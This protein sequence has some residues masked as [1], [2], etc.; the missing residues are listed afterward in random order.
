MIGEALTE[1]KAFTLVKGWNVIPEEKRP[2]AK[3]KL[4]A[5]RDERVANGEPLWPN[6][7]AAR[8]RAEAERMEKLWLSNDGTDTADSMMVRQIDFMSAVTKREPFQVASEPHRYR[9]AVADYLGDPAAADSPEAFD[10]LTRQYI[11][12]QRDRRLLIDG[13]GNPE[14]PDNGSSLVQF[15]ADAARAGR[16]AAESFADWSRGASAKPGYEAAMRE[17]E[18]LF[19]HFSRVHDKARRQWQDFEGRAEGILKELEARTDDGSPMLETAAALPY[20]DG[21]TPPQRDAVLGLVVERAKAKDKGTGQQTGEAVG[22]V[23][24]R[25]AEAQTDSVVRT[26]LGSTAFK[27]GQT[28]PASLAG[29]PGGL[30]RRQVSRTQANVGAG[31]FGDVSGMAGAVDGAFDETAKLTKQQ[32]DAANKELARQRESVA[33]EAKLR[34]IAQGA[35]DPVKGSNWFTDKV[36]YPALNI[37]GSIGSF[38]AP[39]G[40]AANLAAYVEDEQSRLEEAGVS[41]EAV[42]MQAPLVGGV[43]AVLDRIQLGMLRKLPAFSGFAARLTAPAATGAGAFAQRIPGALGVAVG[44]SAIEGMQDA[45]PL[46]IQKVF[47]ALGAD[48]PD[49]E[50]SEIAKESWAAV[51][52]TFFGMLPLVMLGAGVGAARDYKNVRSLVG[53]ASALRQIGFADTQI[54]RI[55]KAGDAEAMVRALRGEWG[56]RTPVIGPAA[57]PQEQANLDVLRDPSAPAGDVAAAAQTQ[58]GVETVRQVMAEMQAAAG[59][60]SIRHTASGWVLV[61]EDGNSVTTA[62]PEEARAAMVSIGRARSEREAR[63]MTDLIEYFGGQDAA[64]GVGSVTSVAKAAVFARTKEDGTTEAVAVNPGETDSEVLNWTDATLGNLAAEM[65]AA[66]LTEAAIL[67]MNSALADDAGRMVRAYQTNAGADI[68]TILHERFERLYREGRVTQEQVWWAAN[69]LTSLPQFDPARIRDDGQRRVAE[70]LRRIATEDPDVTD[71]ER[72]ETMIDLVVADVLGMWQDGTKLPAGAIEAGIMEASMVGMTPED[73]AAMTTF[74]AVWR[75]VKG[76][77]KAMF[78]I[79]SRI[80]SARRKGQI[81]EGDEWSAFVDTLLRVDV[82]KRHVEQVVDEAGSMSIAAAGGEVYQSRDEEKAQT[83]KASSGSVFA[84]NGGLQDRDAEWSRRG[85][86]FSLSPRAVQGYFDFNAVPAEKIEANPEDKKSLQAIVAAE[87]LDAEKRKKE[88]EKAERAWA[89]LVG[90]NAALLPEALAALDQGPVSSL[91]HGLISREIPAWDV[92]GAVIQGPEDILALTQAV[93]SPFV[94]SLK[95]IVVGD[96][97]TVVGSRIVTVG[98]LDETSAHPRE[99]FASIESI[100][101]GY[102]GKIRGWIISHNHP[103]G[104]PEPSQA[105]RRFTRVIEDVSNAYGIPLLD[106]VVTN[107]SRY[108]SFRDAGLMSSGSVGNADARVGSLPDREKPE[109]QKL[110]QTGKAEWEVIEREKRRDF[111]PDVMRE[112]ALNATSTD[113]NHHHV[114][115]LSVRMQIEAIERIKTDNPDEVVKAVIRG[116]GREG[117]KSIALIVAGE[118]QGNAVASKDKGFV[119]KVTDGLRVAMIGVTDAAQRGLSSTWRESG[120]MEQGPA[121]FSIGASQDAIHASLE[122]RAKAGDAAAAQEAQRM[123]D[124]AAE[125]AG[126]SGISDFRMEHSA[127]DR[128]TH[129]LLTVRKSG[130]V[131]ADYWTR[132]DWYVSSPEEM[133]S[134]QAIRS[135]LDRAEAGNPKVR[136]WVFRAVPKSVKETAPRN[137]D[138]VTPSEA[139]AKLEGASI[140]GG[141]KIIKHNALLSELW[142]DGNSA[143]ELGFDDGNGYVYR[144]TK[145]NRKLLDPFTYDEGNLVPLSKRFNARRWETSFSISGLAQISRPTKKDD[146]FRVGTSRRIVAKKALPTPNTSNIDFENV[147]LEVLAKQMAQLNY[148]HLPADIL[149]EQDAR[150]KALKFIEWLRDNLLA[151]HDAFPQDV[152]A[153]ATLWYDGANRIAKRL[154]KQWK[155]TP[156]QAAGVM[157]VLSPQ[158]DWFKNVAQAEQVFDI[159]STERDTVI[160]KEI[161]QTAGE[162]I[163]QAALADSN[164]KRK[165]KTKAGEKES[166]LARTRRIKFNRRLQ[167]AAVEERRVIFR[168]MEGR[169]IAEMDDDPEL[170]AWAIRMLAQHKFGRFYP[171]LSPE[172]DRLDL[173]LT[174]AGRPAFN[175]W[176]SCLEIIKCVSILKDGSLENISAQLGDEHKV[177]SFYNNIIAPNSPFGDTTMDTHAVAAANLMPFA[178][179]DIEVRHNLGS[180]SSS[181]PLGISGMYHLYLK[182]YRDAAA[183]RGLQPRQMQSITWEAIR[184]L[185]PSVEKSSQNLVEQIAEIWQSGEDVSTIR[186]RIL[187]RGIPSPI[188]AGTGNGG[189]SGGASAVV[190]KTGA[191]LESGTDLRDGDRA[192]PGSSGRG[193]RGRG[194]LSFSLGSVNTLEAIAARLEE[195]ASEGGAEAKLEIYQNLSRTLDGMARAARANEETEQIIAAGQ[196]ETKR[197]ALQQKLEDDYILEIYANPIGEALTSD[198]ATA[199]KENEFLRQFIDPSKKGLVGRFR[200]PKRARA[201]GRG[202]GEYED[203]LRRGLPS[204]LFRGPDSPAGAPDVIAS[205]LDMPMDVPEMW[206]RIELELDSVARARASLEK[207]QDAVREAKARARAEAKDWALSERAKLAASD[208][209]DES[210][211]LVTLDAILMQLPAEVRGRLGGFTKLS[212]MKRN[213]VRRAHFL[214]MIGQIDIELERYLR[215]SYLTTIRELFAKSRP[216]RMAGEKDRGRLGVNAHTWVETAE[217]ASKLGERAL[218]ERESWIESRLSGSTPLDDAEIAD[219]NRAWDLGTGEDAARMALEQESAILDLFGGMTHS[220]DGTPVKGSGELEAALQALRATITT[221]RMAREAEILKRRADRETRRLQLQADAKNGGTPGEIKAREESMQGLGGDAVKF[222]RKGFSFEQLVGDIF[223]RGS[224]TH[225]FAEDTVIEA[226]LAETAAFNRAQSALADLMKSLWP[227]TGK[228]GRL[229]NMEAMATPREVPGAPEGS[230]RFSQMEA[231][232]MTMLWADMDSRDWLTMHGFGEET[233]AALEA[234]LTPEAMAIRSWL[235]EWYDAQYDDLNEVYRRIHGTNMPRVRNYSPRMVEHGKDAVAID[236][237][238]MGGLSARGVFSGFTKRRRPALAAAPVLADAL[239]AWAQ[240]QRVVTHFLSWA[241][242]SS[243]L[244]AVF[245]TSATATYVK[246]AAGQQ[247]ATDLNQWL[248]DLEAGG[249]ADAQGSALWKRWLRAN[250][251]DKLFGKLGVLAKQIPAMY[252]SAAEVGWPEWIRSARRVLAG[253]AAR[254]RSEA[255]ESRIMQGRAFTR[256]DEFIQA[257]RARGASP[258][259]GYLRRASGGW[260]DLNAIDVALREIGGAIGRTDAYFTGFSAAVAYDAKFLEAKESGDSDEAAH[261][262]AERETERVISRTAQPETLAN[263]SLGENHLGTWGRILFMFQS[264]NRQALYMTFAAFRDGGMKSPEAWRKAVTHWVLTGLVTQTVGSIV[265]DIM[266]DDDEDEIWEAGDYLRAMTFGPLTG[267][268]HAGPIIDAVASLLGGFERR[269]GVGPA[270]AVTELGKEFVELTKA[271]DSFDWRDAEKLGRSMGLL[272]GGRWAALNVSAN[273]AKQLAGSVDNLYE[274]KE[275]AAEREKKAKAKARKEAK[276]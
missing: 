149:E 115:Y 138:W 268:L 239:Q 206:E 132:P 142:W 194:G 86:S 75:A 108:F 37:A 244:R 121:S 148:P 118:A 196:I 205:N 9:R 74:R 198:A 212:T 249:V 119:R 129:S 215:R 39:G 43:Q 19:T 137:G 229:R 23:F 158:K 252:G 182:A 50:W 70:S 251:A 42:A 160:T 139:Y 46:V 224:K 92:R 120:L 134:L 237:L 10:R 222:A 69:R 150:T 173:V 105:D 159:W 209:R 264:A 223:G 68:R 67:G 211:T 193:G 216:K 151:L 177:R 77:L 52:E 81:K 200:S 3:A 248:S 82:E 21:L 13:D 208:K 122:R 40:W 219:L 36:Y 58:A 234:Y 97:G 85:L 241:E 62:T 267:M 44:E 12:G 48:E 163:A 275:E 152:R 60:R 218:A 172:G 59:I 14:N 99:L 203:A 210:R 155:Y 27:E 72:Q 255:A 30:V 188:W 272:L 232:H 20:L 113:P 95:V 5:Y 204:W 169:T 26:A 190:S 250:T 270:A 154:A 265:R 256:P 189:Q 116:A 235:S 125:A 11:Q 236:P 238:G 65:S 49:V 126:Y 28:V 63:A 276:E 176:G 266:T 135:K 106:H 247:G 90:G 123:V 51:P 78:G 1:D 111:T 73:R 29:D 144:N 226:E 131:P 220:Q 128:T 114:V 271:G 170:Q 217:A 31:F 245:S 35:V 165:K 184:L 261:A 246:A 89:G 8:E 87:K 64:E 187:S 47:D 88:L 32:A 269:Q 17:G 57:S 24:A 257:A 102:S 228:L 34:Q 242:A 207:A 141:Y 259:T 273:M 221:G 178:S 33:I 213:D 136:L 233:Q 56:G 174:N 180:A 110:I 175:T 254:T 55:T 101:D 124:A 274:T 84:R 117:A 253:E 98:L 240:N 140:E 38:A 45:T 54:D 262:Y 167:E 147:P 227:R 104:Q 168:Q 230:P 157:A 16:P 192:A 146:K 15:A 162:D 133:Q 202:M 7:Q 93:R 80:A 4:A 96:D 231:V 197:R 153:R 243:E 100:L 258:V 41:A 164:E 25:L 179:G 94:E 195:R 130:L 201:A 143:A 109:W 112:L 18:G 199:I 107:G 79:A 103:G 127:P 225:R 53:D 181:Q 186:T 260:A 2:L 22:R 166:K 66:G 156:Q 191:E 71:A 91:M 263:K 183:L 83:E 76:Y 185:F 214:K 161:L 61:G 145:N 6:R 171:A